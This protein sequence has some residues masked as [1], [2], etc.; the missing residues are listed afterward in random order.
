[1]EDIKLNRHYRIILNDTLI[2]YFIYDFNSPLMITFS[3][4]GKTLSQKEVEEGKNAWGFDFFHNKG[5]NIISFNAITNKHWFLCDSINDFISGLDS[6]LD[7][8]PSRL[9]YGASMGAFAVNHY[10]SLLPNS[11]PN[12]DILNFQAADIIS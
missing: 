3:P 9:G 8:F 5:F 7:F 12:C 4:A 10:A 1:M 6:F 11:T 2:Q